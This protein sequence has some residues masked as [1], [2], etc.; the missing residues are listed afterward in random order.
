MRDGIQVYGEGYF[1]ASS[2]G[3]KS[4]QRNSEKGNFSNVNDACYL[5]VR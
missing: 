2:Y 4:C 5:C 1:Q 3:M